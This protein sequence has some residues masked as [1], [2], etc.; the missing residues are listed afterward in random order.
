MCGKIVLPQ[1]YTHCHQIVFDIKKEIRPMVTK[2]TIQSLEK[3]E[4][5]KIAIP[6]QQTIPMVIDH[7]G[8]HAQ[9]IE[10][11]DKQVTRWRL[12]F[13]S[14]YLIEHSKLKTH[15]NR[16]FNANNRISSVLANVYPNVSFSHT[17]TFCVHFF[18]CKV[19]HL[20]PNVKLCVKF[21]L[22]ETK[23]NQHVQT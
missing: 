12:V 16:Q 13:P 21:N 3:Q 5:I 15:K 19:S 22:Q 6:R 9:S 2:T 8:E 1:R 17:I 10:W 14:F 20:L 18:I 7:S 11:N 4:I 23:K